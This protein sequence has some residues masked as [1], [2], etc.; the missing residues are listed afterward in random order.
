MS[1]SSSVLI[2]S[3]STCAIA[4]FMTIVENLPIS[5]SAISNKIGVTCLFIVFNENTTPPTVRIK[6]IINILC[7]LI[8]FLFL[9]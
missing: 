2:L 3:S 9:K 4:L 6:V 1:N 5:S 8:F 7:F